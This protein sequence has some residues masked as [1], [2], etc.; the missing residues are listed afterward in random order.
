[1]MVPTK[2]IVWFNNSCCRMYAVLTKTNATSLFYLVDFPRAFPQLWGK[3]LIVS[4]TNHI[5]FQLNSLSYLLSQMSRFRACSPSFGDRYF[6]V[7]PCIADE[8]T[9]YLHLLNLR[10][11]TSS[12][13]GVDYWKYL[14]LQIYFPIEALTINELETNSHSIYHPLYQADAHNTGHLPCSLKDRN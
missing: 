3:R 14:L 1:M 9:M 6:I 2:S 7:S 12:K 10:A 13:I 4:E 5:N 11:C 8:T